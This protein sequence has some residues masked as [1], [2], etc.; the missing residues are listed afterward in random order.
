MKLSGRSAIVT[1]A[2]QGLGLA[3]AEALAEAGARVWVNDIDPEATAKAVSAI[4]D[5]GGVADPLPGDVSA[6]AF[7]DDAVAAVVSAHGSFDILV[8]NAGISHPNMLW[9]LTD[10]QWDAVIAVNLTSAFRA[11]RAAAR[12]MREQ[13]YGRIVNV[14]S[15][16]GI[17][18]SIGQI[19]YSA[20]KAG[21][22]GITK[23]A[24]KELARTGVTVNAIAPVAATPMTEKVRTDERLRE[25]TI[26]KLP[27]QR[28]AEPDEVAPAVVFLASDDA[29]YITGHVLHVDGGLS[30]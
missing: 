29:S 1:G 19:N 2:G 15:A 14:T 10:E 25:K 18:G 26:A 11:V 5:A 20:A 28:W 9:N 24:A 6:T 3:Y 22:I 7:F 23:S 30:I 16:A 8:N 13:R 27:M 17:E 4:E 21:L 12:V